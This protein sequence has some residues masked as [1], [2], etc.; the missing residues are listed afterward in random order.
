MRR[1]GFEE[2]IDVLR[3]PIQD[4]IDVFIPRRPR[5]SEKLGAPFL[6]LRKDGVAQPIKRLSQ[7][8]PPFLVPTRMTAGIAPA[9]AVPSFNSVRATPCAAFPNLSFVCRRMA[10]EIFAVV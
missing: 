6:E 5:I 2:F 7:R 8:S 9:V 4:H 1:L 10:F 3:G